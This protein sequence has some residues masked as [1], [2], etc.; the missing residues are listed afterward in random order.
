MR[1]GMSKNSKY[2]AITTNERLFEAGLLDNFGKACRARDRERMI[3][4]LNQVDLEEQSAAI[5]DRI[6]ANRVLR[7]LKQPT[8]PFSTAL[9]KVHTS[10]ACLEQLRTFRRLFARLK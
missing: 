3:E 10:D 4:L 2:S 8:T 6:L 9:R 1:G 5:A 7:L